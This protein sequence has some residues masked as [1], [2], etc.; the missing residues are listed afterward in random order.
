MKAKTIA[1][2]C[3]L[4]HTALAPTKRCAFISCLTNTSCDHLDVKTLKLADISPDN[5][6]AP[7]DTIRVRIWQAL[8]P[9]DELSLSQLSK[10]VGERH[11]GELRPHLTHVERQVKTLGNKSNEWR[12]RRGLPP[13]GDGGQQKKLR[14][15]FRKGKRNEVYVRLSDQDTR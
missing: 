14:I 10:A 1:V 2:A 15:K 12:I 13:V 7:S 5:D 11:L 4:P 6:S 9:G 8:A 3:S